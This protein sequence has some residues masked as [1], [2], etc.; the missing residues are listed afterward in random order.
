MTSECEPAGVKTAVKIAD[1]NCHWSLKLYTCTTLHTA[2]NSF[3]MWIIRSHA[4]TGK[5]GK[6]CGAFVHHD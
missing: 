6:Q 5:N 3:V 1:V 2:G 4:V